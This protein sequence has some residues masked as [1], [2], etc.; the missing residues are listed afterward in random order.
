M[1]IPNQKSE[2]KINEVKFSDF[3][4]WRYG[5]NHIVN[6]CQ[7]L[8]GIVYCYGCYYYSYLQSFCKIRMDFIQNELSKQGK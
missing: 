4:Y 5:S 6:Q 3:K 2:N 8:F 1:E 7:A